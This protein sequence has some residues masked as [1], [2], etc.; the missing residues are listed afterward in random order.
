MFTGIIES[1][2]KV[3]SIENKGS[4]KSFWIESEISPHLKIDESISHDGVCLTI[5]EFNDTAHKV[6][7]IKETIEK[8]TLA[9]WLPGNIVNLER[10]MLIN[11][12]LDGHI[13]QG[14]IDSTA[15]CINK[16]E[17]N[18]SWEFTFEFDKQYAVLVIEKGSVCLNG[19]SLT[20]FNVRKKKFSVAIIPYTFEHTNFSQIQKDSIINIEFDLMGKYVKRAIDL[21]NI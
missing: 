16:K 3:I 4:N 19:V 9:N 11:G 20:A 21:K 15:C 1:L 10:S 14:H 13:V 17:L 12:R 7:A 8:T 5:E 18:G 2:G 6:T